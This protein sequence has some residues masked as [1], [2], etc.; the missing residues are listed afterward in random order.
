MNYHQG[1]IDARIALLDVIYKVDPLIAGDIINKAEMAVTGTPEYLQ[2]FSE[3]CDSKWRELKLDGPR[4]THD[5]LVKDF[6]IAGTHRRL[7]NAHRLAQD[8]HKDQWRKGAEEPYFNH[9]YR[10]SQSVANYLALKGMTY[11]F[12]RHSV[13]MMIAALLHDVVE[14]CD[15]TLDEIQSLFGLR[16]RTWVDG[17]TNVSVGV[18]RADREYKTRQKLMAAPWEVKLIKCFDIYDNGKTMA[19]QDSN[20]GVRWYPEKLQLVKEGFLN[21]MP[22]LI[23]DL[24]L[25]TLTMGQALSLALT[26]K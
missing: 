24:V 25:G 1:Q 11:A 10:V 26:K 22:A 17:L 14:D 3:Y 4:V 5:E 21:E 16:V 18:N 20:F 23:R 15:V 13:D 9:V 12:E 7:F 2:G 6:G 19:I 8:S